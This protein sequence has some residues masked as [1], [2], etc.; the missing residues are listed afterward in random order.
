MTN[1]KLI[2]FNTVREL[3]SRKI[4]YLLLFIFVFILLANGVGFYTLMNQMPE[5]N[6]ADIRSRQASLLGSLFSP[7]STF[8]ILFGIIF[9]AAAVHWEKKDKTIVGV[10]AKPVSRTQFLLGKIAG[11]WVTIAAFLL[12]GVLLMS[13]IMLMW[14]IPFTALFGSGLAFNLAQLTVYTAISFV[15]SL[16][17]VPMLGGGIAFILWSFGSVFSAMMSADYLALQWLGYL[18]YYLNPA[19]IGDPLIQWGIQNNV[20]DPDMGLY[21]SVIGENFFFTAIVLAL[22]VLLYR[23]RDIV[24][25]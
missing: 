17:L 13:G 21:W 20:I 16:Y 19:T 12:V 11:V 1:I 22:G 9:G 24:M 4:L 14:D 8:S 2:T 18:L 6:P 25:G 7:W 23:R 5:M 15:L 3:L 10:M